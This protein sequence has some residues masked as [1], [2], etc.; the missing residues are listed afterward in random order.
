VPIPAYDED[1]GS[2]NGYWDWSES[3]TGKGS[4]TP[5]GGGSEWNLFAVQPDLGRFVNWY[6]ILGSGCMDIKPKKII[7]EESD[8]GDD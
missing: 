1:A 6:L 5:T 8:G 7:L 3:D 4:I 2:A